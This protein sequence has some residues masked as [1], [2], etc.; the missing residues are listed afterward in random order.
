MSDPASASVHSA[1]AGHSTDRPLHSGSGGWDGDRKVR[2]LQ[3]LS[4]KGDVR[5]AAARVG[6]SRQS[7]YLLRRRDR[8]F[9]QAWSA[10]LV[11]ARTAAE[12]VL[13]TRALDGCEE[14]V[15]FRGE[16][17]GTRRRYDGRLLLAHLGRLDTLTE[18][19][20]GEQA[21]R[22]DELLAIVAGEEFHEDLR[23]IGYSPSV[24]EPVLP[25]NREEFAESAAGL[26]C[27]DEYQTWREK[28]EEGEAEEEDE[29]QPD[30]DDYH[31]EFLHS[32][33][34]WRGQALA[35]VDAALWAGTGRG[36]AA[37][38]G[39]M[40][41]GA[42]EEGA[43]CP[44]IE[45]K[46]LDGPGNGFAPGQC[47][48][49]QVVDS[50]EGGHG[51]A[52]VDRIGERPARF[53]VIEGAGRRGYPPTPPTDRAGR[54][55]SLSGAALPDGCEVAAGAATHAGKPGGRRVGTRL[56]QLL[57]ES[58]ASWTMPLPMRAMP[59]W[60]AAASDRSMTRFE[61]NGPRSLIVTTTESPV[62]GL[63]T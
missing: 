23:D 11:L 46:S 1:H 37:G 27:E 2:F 61:W 53:A 50:S 4:E 7:A 52:K 15:W 39:A 16:M 3:H 26:A 9:G 49:C 24:A 35:R 28:F 19:L 34:A 54:T 56:R 10:A 41:K 6:M 21:E 38:E 17:V 20:A 63:V 44:P 5:A 33:D 14:E 55:F 45:Y 43:D 51:L 36:D 8:A 22:F 30:H 32:W 12:E 42:S 31:A 25:R 47:K 29:P 60:R 40:G 48:P 13:A 18:T 57:G 59:I 58:T 62:R